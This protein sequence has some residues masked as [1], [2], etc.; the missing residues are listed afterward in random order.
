MF[1]QVQQKAVVVKV[2]DPIT[3]KKDDTRIK[4]MTTRKRDANKS[5]VNI[6][7]ETI[8]N[9]GRDVEPKISWGL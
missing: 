7:E 5:V 4:S 2:V 9:R 3:T 8:N 1:L 6:V